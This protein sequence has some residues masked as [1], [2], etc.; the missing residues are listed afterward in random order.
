MLLFKKNTTVE[1]YVHG[2]CNTQSVVTTNSGSGIALIAT[3]AEE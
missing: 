2:L 1:S 3:W